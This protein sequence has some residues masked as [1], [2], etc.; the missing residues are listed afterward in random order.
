MEVVEVTVQI[1]WLQTRANLLMRA[2]RR[3]PVRAEMSKK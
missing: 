2:G 1:W 3:D